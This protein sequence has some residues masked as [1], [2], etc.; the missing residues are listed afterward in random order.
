MNLPYKRYTSLMY[1]MC[2][3]FNETAFKVWL[4]IE[5]NGPFF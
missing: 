2:T 4:K 3:I 5:I 1:K